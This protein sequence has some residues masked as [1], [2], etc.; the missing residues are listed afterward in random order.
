MLADCTLVD[1]GGSVVFSGPFAD[2]P[3]NMEFSP[4]F[5]C[6]VIVRIHAEHDLDSEEHVDARAHDVHC[7]GYLL[8]YLLTSLPYF[9][10]LEVSDGDDD[11]AA[12][13]PAVAEKQLSWAE[14][15][16]AEGANADSHPMLAALK[17]VSADHAEYE[18]MCSLIRHMLQPDVRQ[19]ATVE[20]ALRVD[21]FTDT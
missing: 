11:D 7:A 18:S 6:P 19:R 9:T 3:V 8:F 12:T 21:F 15:C 20:Q 4:D 2:R 16:K 1:L 13:W 14:A 10:P 17:A 5:A